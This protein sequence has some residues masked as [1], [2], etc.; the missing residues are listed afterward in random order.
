LSL[1]RPT[2]PRVSTRMFSSLI[3]RPRIGDGTDLLDF[4]SSSATTKK[5]AA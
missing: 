3:E 5:A 4:V 1:M 2:L